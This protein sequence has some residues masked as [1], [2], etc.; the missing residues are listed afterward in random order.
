LREE[1]E[2]DYSYEPCR[3]VEVFKNIELVLDFPCIDEVEDLEEY[4]NVEDK[5]HLS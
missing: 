5:G 3:F 2:N 4:E 1:D